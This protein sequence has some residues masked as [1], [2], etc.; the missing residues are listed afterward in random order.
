MEEKSL[1]GVFM[2]FNSLELET[3]SPQKAVTIWLPEEY[4]IK[5]DQI[6]KNSGR[7]FC[8]KV[9]EMFML[10]IDKTIEKSA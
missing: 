1:D 3:P 9:R 6:Q 10:A 4:K 2:E 5:Y 7:K 8:K